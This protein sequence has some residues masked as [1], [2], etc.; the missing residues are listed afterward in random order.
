MKTYSETVAIV[1]EIVAEKPRDYRYT[2]DPKTAERRSWYAEEERSGTNCYYAHAD[3]TA[4]CI[5][6]NFIHKLNPEFNLKMHEHSAVVSILH[7]AGIR[8]D[9]DALQFLSDAQAA[10][11]A[12]HT[13]AEAVGIAVQ[14]NRGLLI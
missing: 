14:K 11:D 12:G 6:G 9:G 7:Y 8:V 1:K 10:Q 13:W 4:G 2:D 5:V 3:G